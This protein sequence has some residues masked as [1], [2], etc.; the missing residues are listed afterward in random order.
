MGS[1]AELGP[2]LIQVLSSLRSRSVTENDSCVRSEEVEESKMSYLPARFMSASTRCR[3]ASPTRGR[4]L[5]TVE[6]VVRDTPADVA[7]S[8]NPGACAPTR[9]VLVPDI[10]RPSLSQIGCPLELRPLGAPLQL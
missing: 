3:V 9:H 10:F 5:A 2:M 7:M 4:R 1:G 8:L 6:T